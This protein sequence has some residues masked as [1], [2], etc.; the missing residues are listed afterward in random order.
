MNRHRITIILT[1]PLIVGSLLAPASALAGPMLSGYGG[2]GAGDQAILG[3]TLVGGSRGGGGAGSSGSSTGSGAPQVTHSTGSG[4]ASGATTAAGTPVG[5]SAKGAQRGS[6]ISSH[7]G[8]TSN[9]RAPAYSAQ[10]ASRPQ[11]AAPVASTSG[12]LGLSGSD[13]LI[14]L[15]IA[16]GLVLTGGFTRRLART[17]S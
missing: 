15:I 7:D 13:L 16:G 11:A 5:K 14:I 12:T 9:R 17:S 8:D 4:A 2:P 1:T 10:T 6:R 3:S